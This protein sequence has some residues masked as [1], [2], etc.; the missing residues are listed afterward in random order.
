MRYRFIQDHR[1]VWPVQAQCDVLQVSRSGFYAWRKRPPSPT[2]VR[3]AQLTEQIRQIHARPHHANYGAPRVHRTLL[4]EG[5]PCNRKTV[6]KLMCRAGLRAKTCRRFRVQTTDSRHDLPIAPNR[7][8]RHFNP[9]AKHQAW[10]MDITYIPTDEGW[11]YLALIQD[12]YSRK[13]VGWAMSERIDSAL[14]IDAL[15]M[16]VTG[17]RPQPGLL[18][19]SDRGVQYASQP[20]RERLARHGLTASMSRKANCWD[21]APA[22]SLIATLK[23]ELV[24]QQ[25]YRTRDDARRALFEYIEVFYNRQRRHSSLGYRTPSEVH[26]RAQLGTE[27]RVEGVRGRGASSPPKPKTYRGAAA[28][29]NTNPH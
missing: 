29:L 4:A 11:L 15:E 25:S 16:A 8:N 3:A 18:A 22:E 27:K 14:A 28:P 6:E 9:T 13:I 17:E 2:A 5:C 10:P 7:L 19:H 20:F 12:L 21:N 24:H 26:E 23:K 1:E